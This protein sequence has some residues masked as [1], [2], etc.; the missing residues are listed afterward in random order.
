MFDIAMMHDLSYNIGQTCIRL[1]GFYLLG[2][3]LIFCSNF[4]QCM[5]DRLQKGILGYY[6]A[7]QTLKYTLLSLAK[8]FYS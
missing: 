8:V 1:S 4:E 2:S 5:L 6:F 3:H 7:V